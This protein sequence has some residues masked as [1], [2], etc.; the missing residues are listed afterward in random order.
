MYSAY[1][2]YVSTVADT[3]NVQGRN[4]SSPSAMV[5]FS[6][7]SRYRRCCDTDVYKRYISCRRHEPVESASRLRSCLKH[8][9]RSGMLD[10]AYG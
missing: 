8:A 3:C 4:P 9:K 7:I 6:G 1:K 5:G 2:W 10:A